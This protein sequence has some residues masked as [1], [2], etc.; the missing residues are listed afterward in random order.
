MSFIF[1]L[2][3]GGLVLAGIPVLV[4]LIMR[5]KPKHL[6]FPAFRFLLQRH[7]TNQRKL[8]LRHILLLSL[9]MLLIAAICLA[10][11]RPK[12]FSERL[13]LSADR[14]VAAV[15]LFDTSASMEYTI[16][17]ET[18]LDVA[19]RRAQELLNELPEGSRVAVIDTA[20]PGGEWLPTL[21][22][23]RDRVA[24]RALR[25]ANGPITS[26]IAEAYQLLADLS[27]DSGPKDESAPRFL[28]IFSDRTQD[29][30]DADRVKD[31]RQVRERLGGNVNEV[32][33]DVGADDPVDVAL[34]AID[35]P[36][37]VIPVGDNLIL[38][39]TVRATGADCETVVACRIDGERAPDRK[40]VTLRAGQSQVVTF[41]RRNLS[42]GPHQAEV[43][44]AAPDALPMNNALFATF[45]LRG[46]RKV[47]VLT[48]NVADADY[49]VF[50]L[51]SSKAFQCDVR[52]ASEALQLGPNDLAE[53][54]AVCL[55]SVA[56][57]TQNLWEM[58]GKYVQSGGGLGIMPGGED[59]DLK[60][61][62]EGEAAQALMPG[63]LTKVVQ[64]DTE[65]GAVWKVATYKHAILQPF[66][67]WSQTS[68]IDLIKVPPGA[69]RYWEVEPFGTDAYKIVAY[70]DKESRPALLER[71]FDRKKVK[72]RV[73]LFT[74]ALDQAHLR[75]QKP[76]ND[77]LKTSFYLVL[78]NKVVGFL[79][80]EAEEGG[81]NYLAGQ[82]VTVS[83]P[84]SSR[85]STYALR[86]PGLSASEATVRRG[87]GRTEL[88]FSQAVTP[89][90]YVLM[91]PDGKQTAQFS[92]NIPAGESELTRVPTEQI[93]AVFGP[94]SILP[95][96]LG[97]SFK[98]ALQG[99]WSQ[100][101]ELFPWLMIL[102][103]LA[104]AV[105]NLLANKFYKRDS[106]EPREEGKMNHGGSESSE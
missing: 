85:S 59:L 78:V 41:E 80:G 97:T 93:E 61:Y 74:T 99:H 22:L 67:E 2:L 51:R 10:L 8:R 44:L 38:R 19:K 79:A 28:Y 70:S 58:L 100:P 62:N 101:L 77:Y 40:Q 20:E 42:P 37:Q 36:R 18:R 76:W 98:E 64:A 49:L 63:R 73:I 11:A 52:P 4:H 31:L 3:L 84:P 25:P 33:V 24:D 65:G 35:L 75:A 57:P 13:N 46:G 26:R 83:L 87:E 9:R 39:A 92:V 90:N 50:A 104:L 21:S 72:G 68:N 15:L 55:L 17:G 12:V 86:G 102:L 54:K 94:G 29:S 82:A 71:N 5:Q 103:L 14:P 96:N 1:P 88:T 56:H 32:F 53:Y 95:L 105:E 7:R 66:S 89:G 27:T 91:D 69:F 48:D 47:L 43:T 81:F 60:A 34:T 6:L 30:W 16:K 106:Q 45:E 23:A